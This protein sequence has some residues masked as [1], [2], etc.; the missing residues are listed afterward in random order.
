MKLRTLGKIVTDSAHVTWKALVGV[1]VTVI[2]AGSGGVGFTLA[3][4]TNAHNREF[5]AHVA[6]PHADAVPRA[7]YDGDMTSVQDT[8]KQ[9]REDMKEI[10]NEVLGALRE[11]R[12][13]I[14]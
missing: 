1:L 14:D 11:I 6:V 2:V 3:Q 10:R 8:L 12:A 9:H 13:S 7:E 4:H 5:A